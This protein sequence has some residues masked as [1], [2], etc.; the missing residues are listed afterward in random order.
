MDGEISVA[1][2]VTLGF[3]DDFYWSTYLQAIKFE[4]SDGFAV[5][6]APYTMFDTGSS[7]IMVPPLLYEPIIEHIINATDRQAAFSTQQGTTFVDC[8]Q[9]SLFQPIEFMFSEYY[10][11]IKPEHY[12]WD[13]YGDGSACTILMSPHEYEF[14][15]MGLPLF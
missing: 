14:F 8:N 4:D 7:H 6:G 11:E 9:M 15:I 13:I 1:T 5:D 2:T 10:L 3:N 12:I